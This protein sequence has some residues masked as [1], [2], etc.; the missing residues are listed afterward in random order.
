MKLRHAN[1]N[2]LKILQYWDKQPHIIE[3]IPDTDWNWAFELKRKPEW[4]EQLIAEINN[5]PIGFVQI[6]DPAIE[7]THYWGNIGANKRAIDIWIGEKQY[8]GK[9]YGNQ[10]MQLAIEKCFANPLVDEILLDPLET[11]TKAIKFYEQ[12]GFRFVEYRQF[13]DVKSPVYALK[14]QTWLNQIANN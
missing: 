13:P 11:N 7:E 8:L 14:K 3:T 12:L 10:M 5:K 2:D 6:I 9:G 4:R 1:I